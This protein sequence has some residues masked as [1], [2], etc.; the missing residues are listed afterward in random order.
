MMINW[1]D[2]RNFDVIEESQEWVISDPNTRWQPEY[3]SDTGIT[4]PLINLNIDS[5][6]I[7]LMGLPGSNPTLTLFRNRTYRFKVNSPGHPFQITTAP[8]SGSQNRLN[9]YVTN[10]GTEYGTVVFKTYD[11]PLYGSLPE[12][13]YYQCENHPTMNGVIRLQYVSDILHY[14]TH[15]DGVTS[16][17]L[18]ISFSSHNDLDRLGWGMG[19]PEGDNAWKYYSL[20]EYIPDKN[21][22][23]TYISNVIDWESGLTTIDYNL[24]SYDIWTEDS[25]IM[26]TIIEKTLRQGL[27]LFDGI[28]SLTYY[29]TGSDGTTN[30]IISDKTPGSSTVNSYTT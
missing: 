20:Y 19:F 9:G 16:Y 3:I 18:N 4:G 29:N 13:L 12:Y 10:Q 26:D 21:L 5:G 24:S 6:V 14:S 17:N 1:P 25:G 8:G 11:D 23:Q 7:T 28:K 2:F 30:S 22:D 27:Q 15:W